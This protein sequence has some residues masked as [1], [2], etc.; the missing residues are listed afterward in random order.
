MFAFPDQFVALHRQSLESAQAIALASFA[1]F[2]KLTQ[3]NV[4]AG[5][6]ELE[7]LRRNRALGQPKGRGLDG[8]KRAPRDGDVSWSSRQKPQGHMPGPRYPAWTRTCWRE[9]SERESSSRVLDTIW[10]LKTLGCS[11]VEDRS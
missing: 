7:A 5:H 1:G 8:S 6:E 10:E 4:Q 9:T 11:W 2:E 3:L